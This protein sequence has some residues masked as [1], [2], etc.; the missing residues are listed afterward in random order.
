VLANSRPIG[1]IE[2]KV[3]RQLLSRRLSIKAAVGAT[4]LD[5]EKPDWH[6]P[7]FSLMTDCPEV[8]FNS[9]IADF[10]GTGKTI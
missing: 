10:A 9:V 5:R 7:W 4:L 8:L 3:A 6:T 2:V 1:I